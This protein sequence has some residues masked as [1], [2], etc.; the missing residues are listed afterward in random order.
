MIPLVRAGGFKPRA[1]AS[2]C[3]AWP[4]PLVRAGGFKLDT[5]VGRLPDKRSRS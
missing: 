4:I 1:A 2:A 5:G 3:P